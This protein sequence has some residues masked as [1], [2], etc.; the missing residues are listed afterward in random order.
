LFDTTTE[1]SI[2]PCHFPRIEVCPFSSPGCLKCEVSRVST[3]IDS[4]VTQQ[5]RS[6]LAM[7]THI[8]C[9]LFTAG[10]DELPLEQVHKLA[11]PE[12]DINF[13]HF[14]PFPPP[15]SIRIGLLR[16]ETKTPPSGTTGR[17]GMVIA[18]CNPQDPENQDP[19]QT[20]PG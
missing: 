8:I 12:Q 18:N 13:P 1:Y 6:P 14:S 4:I 15:A 11:S 7:C 9:V 3:R 5:R 2:L 19:Y 17:L 10:I 16:A 20:P